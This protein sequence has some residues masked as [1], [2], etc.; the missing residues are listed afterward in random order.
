M[1]LDAT[2]FTIVL[3]GTWFSSKSFLCECRSLEGYEYPVYI[4]K[5]CPKNLTEWKERSNALS[6]NASNAYMCMPNENITNLLE[7]CYSIGQILVEKG[8]CLFLYKRHSTVD[9]YSCHNFT[10]GCPTSNYRSQEVEKYPDCVSIGN[11]CFL[12]EPSCV[13]KNVDTTD[14][15]DTKNNHL[16]TI[17]IVAGVL[18]FL[19]V[20]IIIIIIYRKIKSKCILLSPPK[21]KCF[22]KL[23]C[24]SLK[25][26]TMNKVFYNKSEKFLGWFTLFLMCV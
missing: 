15:E 6:C 12:A 3:L 20:A 21:K 13:K 4:T 1:A 25:R 18:V 24:F 8:L 5:A 16:N 7:F 2:Q 11:G 23:F 14:N 22:K 19:I 26:L 10:Y 9:D 17:G